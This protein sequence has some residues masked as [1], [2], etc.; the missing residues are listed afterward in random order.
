MSSSWS[1]GVE[2]AGSGVSTL[3]TLGVGLCPGPCRAVI[4]HHSVSIVRVH[5]IEIPTSF[6]SLICSF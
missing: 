4:Y 6:R 1:T 2:G 3:G 5:R